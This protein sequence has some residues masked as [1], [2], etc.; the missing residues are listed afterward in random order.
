MLRSAFTTCND[1]SSLEIFASR[2]GLQSCK[3]EASQSSPGSLQLRDLRGTETPA[4]PSKRLKFSSEQ[5]DGMGKV[6]SVLLD[7][8]PV[9]RDE[10]VRKEAGEGGRAKRRRTVSVSLAREEC[11][12][13]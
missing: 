13:M 5:D 7:R 12:R 11:D 9:G 8:A 1:A 10:T 2:T 6:F 4:N 3:L